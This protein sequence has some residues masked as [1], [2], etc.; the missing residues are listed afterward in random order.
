M[1]PASADQKGAL[2]TASGEYAVPII[3]HEAY[4]EVKKEKPPFAKVDAEEPEPEQEIP[5]DFQ[6]MICH[7]LLHDAVLIACCGNSYCDE[8]E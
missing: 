2:L 5:E 6:C 4:K 3:D 8:C 7:N 1:I